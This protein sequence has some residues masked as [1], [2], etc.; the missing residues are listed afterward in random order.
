MD[1]NLSSSVLDTPDFFWT[2][3]PPLLPLYA[4]MRTYLEI[5]PRVKTLNERCQVFL[6][7]AEIL[8]DSVNSTKMSTLTWI[9]IVLILISIAVTCTEVFMRFGILSKEKGHDGLQMV[10]VVTE[11][12]TTY[13]VANGTRFVQDITARISQAVVSDL[14][15][16]VGEL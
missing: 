16:L 6:D 9:I 15:G 3:E 14:G 4:S 13:L 2:D 7:L 12:G 8:S 10:K 1:V 5:D 11:N